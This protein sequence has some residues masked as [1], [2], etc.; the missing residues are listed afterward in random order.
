MVTSVKAA[1]DPGTIARSQPDTCLTSQNLFWGRESGVIVNA[2]LS[3]HRTTLIF[4]NTQLRVAIHANF[5]QSP[6]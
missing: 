2:K 5:H 4:L 3:G 1:P 6:P